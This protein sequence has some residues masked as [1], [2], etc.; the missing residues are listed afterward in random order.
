[1]PL[2]RG[3]EAVGGLCAEGE[4]LR[5]WQGLRKTAPS[6]WPAEL[7]DLSATPFF[8]RGSG[9]AEGTLCPRP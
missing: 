7:L 2:V 9:Y 4:H 1:M 3:G 5:E 6:V 8:L